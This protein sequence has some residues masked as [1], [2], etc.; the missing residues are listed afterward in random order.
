MKLKKIVIHNLEKEQQGIAKLRL[1]AKEL[2]IHDVH[3]NFM[4]EVKFVYY[5]KSN[6]QFGTFDPER[7]SFPFQT[8]LDDYLKKKLTFFT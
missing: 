1:A 4:S 5:K 2:T 8:F 3:T 7:V 6:P